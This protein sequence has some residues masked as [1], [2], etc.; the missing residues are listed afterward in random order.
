MSPCG[1]TGTSI[2]D[3]RSEVG[4]FGVGSSK[5][6]VRSACQ[7]AGRPGAGMLKAESSKGKQ[8]IVIKQSGKA[9]SHSAAVTAES[10]ALGCNNS[11]Q[12]L[13]EFGVN[14]SDL[15]GHERM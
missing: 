10:S 6:G 14:K 11:A 9:V 2:T 5:F 15:W 7:E 13:T 8:K 4:E 12:Q 1:K 3:K